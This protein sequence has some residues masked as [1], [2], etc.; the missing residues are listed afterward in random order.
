VEST[1]LN[2][3]TPTSNFWMVNVKLYHIYIRII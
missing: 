2:G 1:S 3:I